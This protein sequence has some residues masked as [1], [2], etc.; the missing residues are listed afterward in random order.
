MGSERFFAEAGLADPLAAA[1]GR[2]MEEQG[3]TVVLVAEDDA[4]VLD[5]VVRGLRVQGFDVAGF[6]DPREALAAFQRDPLRWSLV[7][8]D[9]RMP[10]MTGPELLRRIRA[11]RADLPALLVSGYA[12]RA[13]LEAARA[14]DPVLGKP[15]SLRQ[16]VDAV[17][18]RLADDAG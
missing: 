12:D 9:V 3:S 15:F 17:R 6:D 13:E 1:E 11:E 18:Q 4:S 14:R 2:R 5:V 8:S 7:V 10:W 16:L